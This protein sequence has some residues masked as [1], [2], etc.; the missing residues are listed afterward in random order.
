MIKTKINFPCKLCG[1]KDFYIMPLDNET[2]S[3]DIVKSESK[4]KLRCHKCGK[5]YTLSVVITT[6]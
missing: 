4:F 1:H 6:D 2:L 5:L 3:G